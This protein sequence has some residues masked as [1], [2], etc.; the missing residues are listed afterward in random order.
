ME[1]TKE[2]RDETLELRVKGRLDAYWAD[3]LANA[4]EEAIRGGDHHVRLDLAEVSYLSSAGIRI[5][6]KFFRQLERIRG[7]L[8]VSRPSEA[9]RT[10]LGLAGLTMLLLS[11]PRAPATE[12]PEAASRRLERDGAALEVFA[13]TPGS[14]LRCRAVGAPGR[15]LEGGFRAEDCHTLRFP[16]STFGLGV[17]AF[18]SG[19]AD[20]RG[21]FGEFLVAAGAA[22]YLPTDGTNVADD[23]VASG[24]LVP[25]I[26]ALYALACEGTFAHLVRFEASPAR[27]RIT[28]AELARVALDIAGAEAVGMVMVAESAGLVGAALRRSPTADAGAFGTPEMREWLSFTTEPAYGRSLVLAVGVAA[29]TTPPDV[30]AWLRP[31]ET[32]DGPAGHF[33][34]AA[35]SYHAFPKGLLELAP[36]VATLFESAVLQGVLHLLGDDREPSGVGQ[37]EFVRGAC[38]LG[39]IAVIEREGRAR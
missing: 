39:P 12:P 10:V 22:A 28:L 36:T 11:E 38:W 21:R 15:L 13:A 9:V 8:T 37:S 27:G 29:R 31:L 19:F 33:H 18:G 16:A 24:D 2:R 23:L 5:L 32:P 35:F 34:A 30:A 20:C 6:L 3:H 1:I 4:L 7:E 17:G 26:T 25:E 14:R